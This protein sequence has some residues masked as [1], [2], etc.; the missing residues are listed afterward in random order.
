ML[1]VAAEVQKIIAKVLQT[2]RF[3]VT[4][5]PLLFC[6][7]QCK[8]AVPSTGANTVSILLSIKFCCIMI[9]CLFFVLTNIFVTNDSL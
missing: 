4:D 1:F 5:H 2:C 3:A 6:R 8:F 7:I 9:F